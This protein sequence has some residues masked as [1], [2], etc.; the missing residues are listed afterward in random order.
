MN[1]FRKLGFVKLFAAGNR[2]LSRYRG[3]LK[4]VIDRCGLVSAR[5]ESGPLP[6]GEGAQGLAWFS[7]TAPWKRRRRGPGRWNPVGA[8]V[9][10]RD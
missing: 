1:R 4:T 10:W 6:G 3:T 7:R 8:L 9:E 2:P 5:P